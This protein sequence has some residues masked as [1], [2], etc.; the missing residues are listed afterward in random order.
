[1]A[2]GLLAKRICRIRRV[3]FLLTAIAGPDRAGRRDEVTRTLKRARLLAGP[4]VLVVGLTLATPPAF[5]ADPATAP[6]PRPITAAAAARVKAMPAATLAQAAPAAQAPTAPAEA[7]DKP[8]FK[9][10]KGA[11]ALAL[12]AGAFG[13]V[14]YSID[15]D[16]VKSPAK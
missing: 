3:E 4:L 12:L 15:N 1:M 14:L 11:I 6:S 2:H 10:T 16:R 9:T 8:F 13:Y 7:G 5:A